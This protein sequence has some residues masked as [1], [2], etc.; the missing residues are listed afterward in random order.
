ERFLVVFLAGLA[1]F[2]FALAIC[3][4]LSSFSAHARESGHP[5]LWLW[6]PAFAGTSGRFNLRGL[7]LAVVGERAAVVGELVQQR[8]RLVTLVARFPGKL[9]QPVADFLQADRVG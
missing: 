8:G 6:V 9:A 7:L 5:V 1:A 3:C 2:F 4:L